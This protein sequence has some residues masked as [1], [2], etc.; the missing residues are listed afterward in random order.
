MNASQLLAKGAENYTP[1]NWER[2]G[3]GN[4]LSDMQ[5]DTHVSM[6]DSILW[7]DPK[8]ETD[9]YDFSTKFLDIK[10]TLW[11]ELKYDQKDIPDG[12]YE[13]HIDNVK[14]SHKTGEPIQLT[15]EQYEKLC[16]EIAG[17]LRLRPIVETD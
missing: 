8:E 11:V 4:E 16:D 7:I 9:T 6:I 10:A 17:K 13:S 14:V 2:I 3:S 15:D 12:I 1:D 5:F